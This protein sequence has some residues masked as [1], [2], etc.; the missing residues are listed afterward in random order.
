MVGTVFEIKK[1]ALE[2]IRN[3]A[4]HMAERISQFEDRNKLIVGGGE[5]DSYNTMYGKILF[6]C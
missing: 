1:S 5:E 6:M 2:S 3:R 4:D